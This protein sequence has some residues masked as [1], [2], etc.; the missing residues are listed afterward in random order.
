MTKPRMFIGSSREHLDLA[1]AV[2][3]GLEHDVEPTVWAQGVFGPSRSAMASLVDQTNESD[4]AVFIF[5]PSDL[6]TIRDQQKKTVRDNVIF[7]LGLF[8]GSIGVERCFMIVPRGEENLH[9]PS[10]MLGLVPLEFDPNRQDENLVAALGPACN[11]IRKAVLKLG[12]LEA[13]VLPDTPGAEDQAS[14]NLISDPE[15]CKALLKSWLGS[16]STAEMRK[17]FRYATV[18][19]SLE[20]EPGSTERYIEELASRWG[21]YKAHGGKET[22]V[23]EKRPPKVYRQAT[24]RRR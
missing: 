7:E 13:S 16:R 10:D 23:F 18:D 20:L 19:S 3:E 1:Y 17:A 24:H 14:A 21:Y 6:T 8:I 22:I 11:K 2:Q 9:L 12:A 5:S 4:F 15:D